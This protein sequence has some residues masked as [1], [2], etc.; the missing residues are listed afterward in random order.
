MDDWDCVSS[1]VM[2]PPD[3]THNTPNP[4]FL[5]SNWFIIPLITSIFVYHFP[6]SSLS[7]F[8]ELLSFR[9]RV[10]RNVKAREKIKS[11][12]TAVCIGL[13]PAPLTAAWHATANWSWK[14]LSIGSFPCLTSARHTAVKTPEPVRN[15]ATFEAIQ[16]LRRR[17]AGSEGS[18]D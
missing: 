15:L 8:L 7:M 11:G 1:P 5:A 3:Q 12:L 14:L 13:D 17:R 9:E 10:Y 16:L 2:L 18:L 4:F 6:S